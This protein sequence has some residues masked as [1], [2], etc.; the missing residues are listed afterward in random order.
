MTAY[1][2][3]GFPSAETLD[4]AHFDDSFLDE[5]AMATFLQRAPNL[6][7]LAYSHWVSEETNQDWDACK[8]VR[9]IEP[10]AGKHLG[11]LVIHDS[12]RR[13]IYAGG[14][15][16]QGFKRLRRLQ[17]P[18]EF[19]MCNLDSDASVR[20][21]EPTDQEL[22]GLQRLTD[23]LVPASVSELSIDSLHLNRNVKALRVM[24]CDFAGR[25]GDWVPALEKIRLSSRPT[26]DGAYKDAVGKLEVEAKEAGVILHLR[27]Y[28][29]EGED[30]HWKELSEDDYYEEME[31]LNSPC[32]SPTC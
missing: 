25:K 29:D 11:S 10:E 28:P 30:E 19:A 23:T 31:R 12:S 27:M 26:A 1:E 21:R 6:R 20:D 3:A 17:L 14:L 7:E 9:A 8:F 16:M 4:D 5:V 2:D 18:L 22:R 32:K 15:S 24:F 13:S